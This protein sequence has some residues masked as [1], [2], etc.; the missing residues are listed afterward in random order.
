MR[1]VNMR[2]S[3][4]QQQPDKMIRSRRD[5]L[6]AAA[7]LG[8][9]SAL[10]G[11]TSL[12]T[13]LRGG[14]FN[15]ARPLSSQPFARPNFRIEDV[16]R[17][18]VGLRPFRQSGFVVRAERMANKLVIHNYGHG[19]AGITLSWGSSALALRELPDIA[20]KR[21]AIIGAGVMG[22]TTARLAQQQGW[23]VTLYADLFSPDTTSDIA[24]GYWAPTGVSR[25]P[26]ETPAFA[27]QFEEALALSL[28][29]FHA[30]AGSTYGVSRRE[31]YH[32]EV[33]SPQGSHPSYLERWPQFFADAVDLKRNEHPFG[34]SGRV[35][36]HS[37]LLI[38]PAIFLPR[39]TQEIGMLGGRFVRQR[40]ASRD[41]LLSLSEP[42]IANCTG[43]GARELFGDEE[44]TPIRG[45]IVLM[46]PDPAI[47]FIT[48]G[49]GEGLM[50]MFPRTHDILLG[51]TFERG[52]SHT[53]ADDATTLRILGEHRR[54]FG[55][56][57]V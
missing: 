9:A 54:M 44:L 25:Q 4:S 3:I 31:N 20:D 45:Q 32:L 30:Q 50:Y 12:A 52:L 19:G 23:Q 6:T 46:K 41:A 27:A 21:L 49:A 51:G 24:G 13:G 56:M 14:P 22:L 47:D 2:G 36:R 42:V 57:R 34:V 1:Y 48:H 33:D 53:T 17:V 55:A 18:R 10:A 26:L 38:E 39:L 40:F 37:S 5:W 16:Q 7:A 11:C 28:A 15:Y 8:G 29:T 43:L 35:V